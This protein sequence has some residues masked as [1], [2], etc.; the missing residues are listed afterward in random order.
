MPPQ[1]NSP[2]PEDLMKQLAAIPAK[3]ECHHPRPQ[4]ADRIVSQYCESF[5]VGRI[6]QSSLTNNSKFERERECSHA[7]KWKRTISTS[8]AVAEISRGRLRTRCQLTGVVARKNCPIVVSKSDRLGKE[9]RIPKYAKFLKK[10]CVH[11]RKKMKGSVEVGDIVS[12]L[13]KNEEKCRD[14]GI[15]SVPCTIGK[16]TFANAMLDLGASINVMPT[17]IYKALN[18]GDL[19]P[20]GVTIQLANRS[21]V[22]PLDID[23]E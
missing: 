19:E 4:N 10:L 9:T 17:S 15:F 21:V 12:A 3:Y 1:G 11:K 14:P 2:S 16:C 23:N 13:T 20:I 8:I 6:Q 18:F 5:T 7:E 22:Q